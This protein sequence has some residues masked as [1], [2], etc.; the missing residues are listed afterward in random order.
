MIFF[1]IISDIIIYIL[2]YLNISNNILI[3]TISGIFEIVEGVKSL[4]KIPILTYTNLFNT[5][6]YISVLLGFSSLSVIFQIK[7]EL[8]D[9]NINISKIIISKIIHGILSGFITYILLLTTNILNENLITTYSSNMLN[10]NEISKF[11][12]I[13]INSCAIILFTI[14]TY[15]VINYM[16]KKKV[17][18]NKFLN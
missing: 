6:I 9:T 1:N 4:T 12:N 18:I 14:S 2:N 5:I 15:I 13:Y 7:N 11:Y 3:S 8:K 10:N 16:F 17:N